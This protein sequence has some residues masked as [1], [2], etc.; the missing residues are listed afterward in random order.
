MDIILFLLDMEVVM[1][2]TLLTNNREN[3]KGLLLELS[4]EE[5]SKFP[6]LPRV[7]R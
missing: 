2:A 6:K 3:F 4:G 1:K 7:S 5:R